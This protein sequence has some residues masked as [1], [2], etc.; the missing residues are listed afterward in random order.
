MEL[1]EDIGFGK[2]A[3]QKHIFCCACAGRF[4]GRLY[5]LAGALKDYDNRRKSEQVEQQRNPKTG[6]LIRTDESA[7]EPA[8]VALERTR[9]ASPPR[10]SRVARPMTFIARPPRPGEG[11]GKNRKKKTKSLE[12]VAPASP[13]LNASVAENMDA[14]E[15][16]RRAAQAEQARHVQAKR[17]AKITHWRK[18]IDARRQDPDLLEVTLKQVRSQFPEVDWDDYVRN[19][20]KKSKDEGEKSAKA[21][22][23]AKGKDKDEKAEGKSKQKSGKKNN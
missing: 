10:F 3:Y 23:K 2:E 12:P 6:E 4:N 11:I 22:K 15:A 8:T 7:R 19:S 9:E 18:R 21:K 1:A 14:A 17:E 5:P 13:S 16:K 20:L